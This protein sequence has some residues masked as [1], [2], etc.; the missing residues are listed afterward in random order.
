VNVGVGAYR[1]DDGLPA[2]LPVVREAEK[3]IAEKG[4]DHEY[5][6]IAGDP[7]FVQLALK[8][9]YGEDSV[10]L[11]EKRVAGVQTLSGTGGLRV[12][13]SRRGTY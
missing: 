13:S 6:G 1:S 7:V 12:V 2:V 3:I 8:F 11:A 10:P 4:L 5:L 9:A